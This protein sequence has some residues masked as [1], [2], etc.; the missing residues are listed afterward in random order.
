MDQLAQQI[1]YGD[2]SCIDNN[3]F[4]LVRCTGHCSSILS[5]KLLSRISPFPQFPFTLFS[6]DVF[7]VKGEKSIVRKSVLLRSLYKI[8]D[9]ELIL[10]NQ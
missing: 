6:E 7:Q 10:S 8:S 1:W 4:I 9:A 3:F 2:G 5:G